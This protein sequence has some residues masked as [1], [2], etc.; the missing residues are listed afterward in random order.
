[1][2]NQNYYGVQKIDYQSSLTHYKYIKRVK[3]NGK[4]RYYYDKDGLKNDV[5]DVLGYDEK[6]AR[7]NAL[8]AKERR[9]SE[10]NKAEKDLDKYNNGWLM[11]NGSDKYSQQYIRQLRNAA[12]AEKFLEKKQKD[13]NKTPLGMLEN[14]KGVI[15]KGEKVVK[16]LFGIKEKKTTIKNNVKKIISDR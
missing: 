13:F 14:A 9:Y 10:L 6:N 12:R 3:K 16:K 8:K 15:D 7:D 2:N 4:W 5:K 1:M 11:I